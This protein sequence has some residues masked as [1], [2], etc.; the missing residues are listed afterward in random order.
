MTRSEPTATDDQLREV[1]R[2]MADSAPMPPEWSQV[3]R[4]ETPPHQTPKRGTTKLAA[5]LAVA[6]AAI[7]LIASFAVL[8]PGTEVT[9]DAVLDPNTPEPL[10]SVLPPVRS[11]IALADLEPIDAQWCATRH[12]LVATQTHSEALAERSDELDGLTDGRSRL[13]VASRVASPLQALADH[14]ELQLPVTEAADAFSAADA[15]AYAG[16]GD[17]DTDDF[18]TA[19][20]AWDQSAD[21]LLAQTS[22]TWAGC[23]PNAAA[24]DD[25]DVAIERVRCVTALALDDGLL[26]L[27]GDVPDPADDQ[28][29]TTTARSLGAW[30]DRTIND[31]TR[32][33]DEV[34]LVLTGTGEDRADD[35][36]RLRAELT[37]L[38]ADPSGPCGTDDTASATTD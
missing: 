32:I 13:G 20:A 7:V 31:T 29:V 8:R 19:L 12:N 17:D 27:A 23:Q 9:P 21:D 30:F 15:L 36:T 14:T 2:Q 37:A 5:T 34:A 4:S 18:L 6:A 38:L 33:A 11:P 26:R 22:A 16:P 25:T 28:L 24:L 1:V 10:G 3:S 35:L